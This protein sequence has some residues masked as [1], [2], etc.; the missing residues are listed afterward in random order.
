MSENY[1]SQ[2]LWLLKGFDKYIGR[3][4]QILISR[5]GEEQGNA[6]IRE[7]H[8]EY[9]ALIPQIP[10]IG[11]KNPFLIF[12][13]PA[14]RN[15]AIYRVLQRQGRTIEDAGQLIYEMSEA[16][17]KAIPRLIRRMI[18][19]FWFSRW[20]LV[21]AKKWAI[22]SQKREYPGSFVMTYVEGNGRDF[23]YGVDYSECAICKFL[24]AQN[25]LELVPYMCA[26]DKIGSELLGWGLS[27]TMTIAKGDEKCDFR[28][29]K[30]G[31]TDI[32]S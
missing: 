2:K 31:T 5:F 4:K 7:S 21:L 30:G 14:S 24:S 19:Y 13:L 15:L 10:Y 1:V 18:E 11:N 9:E 27:R 32:L 25:A 28:Y 17:W 22:E 16:K 3:V 26:T 23:D 8:Y 12:L 20:S 29:K 6:L